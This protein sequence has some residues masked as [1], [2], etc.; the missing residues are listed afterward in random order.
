MRFLKVWQSPF[1]DYKQKNDNSLRGQNLKWDIESLLI[2][3]IDLP[4][5]NIK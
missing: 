2:L 1:E 5:T 3:K 4:V